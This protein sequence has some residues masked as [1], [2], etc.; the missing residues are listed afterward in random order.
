MRVEPGHVEQVLHQLGLRLGAPLQALE[1]AYRVLAAPE[2]RSTRSQFSI[3]ASGVRSSWETTERNSSLARFAASASARA[4][5]AAAS[6]SSRSSALRTASVL[7]R[8]TTTTPATS[9]SVTTGEAL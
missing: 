4:R 2:L 6:S 7:S 5:S 1:G 8:N 9:P 3:D